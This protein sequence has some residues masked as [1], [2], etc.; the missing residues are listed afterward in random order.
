MPAT[1]T[2]IE[3]I[4]GKL[5]DQPLL[6]QYTIKLVLLVAFLELILYRLVSR[7]GM[8]LSKLAADH[9]WIIPTFT[10]LTE[11]GQWLLN[12]V[13]ILLFLGLTVGMANR[14]AA[15]GFTGLTRFIV[16]CIA[17]LLLLTIGFLF[18]PPSML[19]S[20]IYNTVALSA[21]VLLMSEY[22]STHHDR[23]HRLLG[24]TYLLGIGGWLYYQIVSTFF[25]FAGTV[26]A[27]P[28]VYEAHRAGEAFM[29]LASILVFWAYGR[30]VSFRSRNQRQRHRAIW[31]W[32]TAAAIFV[33]MFFLD[34]LL[35]QYNPALATNI[36]KAADGIGWIFQFGMGYTFYLPFALYMAGLSVLVLYRHQAA[37]HG[38]A[39][40]LRPGAHVYRGLC[41]LVLESDADGRFGRHVVDDGPLPAR[42]ARLSD[43]PGGDEN[44]RLVGRRTC[45]IS[46]IFCHR[47]L[48]WTKQRLRNRAG[49]RWIRAISR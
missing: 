49:Q 43:G 6:F 3:R 24:I 40:G 39:G 27:P 13:A 47:G 20:A 9:Q 35:N 15:R 41:A 12:V 8:H 33:S 38:T 23:S 5:S 7:L 30:G 21:I 25:S 17:L 26:V 45:V 19:G 44:V 34:Y 16:P 2:T 29:V 31:F 46:V 48:S 37:D 32:S 4:T 14:L 11:V 42:C 18:V 28:M 36:R 1:A 22:L 10:A